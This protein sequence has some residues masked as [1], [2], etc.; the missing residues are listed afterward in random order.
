MTKKLETWQ[1]W[2]AMRK[3]L[4]DS[5]IMSVLGRR[6]ARTIRMYAQDPRFTVDRCKD[7]IEALAILFDELATY[8]RADIAELAIGHMRQAIT[9]HDNLP[10]PDQLK[11]TMDAEV[12]ADFQ[13][14]AELK[15]AIDDGLPPEQVYAGCW[16]QCTRLNARMPNTCRRR[17]MACRSKKELA[18]IAHT[19]TGVGW[20]SKEQA[21][22]YASISGRTLDKRLADGLRHSR[23]GGCVRIKYTD[24]D[25]Y[26]LSHQAGDSFDHAT[27]SSIAAEILE[28]LQ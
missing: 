27:C 26:L 17:N 13:A 11:S 22:V 28:G 6:N 15:A 20:A 3:T 19:V 16:R 14:V 10:C 18:A 23:V 25:E 8:G 9:G 1:I 21:C 5:F 4:G 12:V 7:P 2:H 24:I